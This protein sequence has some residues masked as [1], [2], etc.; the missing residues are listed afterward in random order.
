M[1]RQQSPKL[2][3]VLKGREGIS[4]D[5]ELTLWRVGSGEV[6]IVGKKAV[7][8]KLDRNTGRP[9]RQMTLEEAVEAAKG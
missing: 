9:L 7:S 1:A 6:R 5:W 3:G 2:M 4:N 8:V